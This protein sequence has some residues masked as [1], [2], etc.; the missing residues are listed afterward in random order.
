M[1]R[2]WPVEGEFH[3]DRSSLAKFT[4]DNEFTAMEFDQGIY[5]RQTKPAP[6]SVLIG[7]NF[8]AHDCIG[9]CFLFFLWNAGADVPK[10]CNQGVD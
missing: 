10:L 7:G 6:S 2:L 9:M 5:D 3:C 1:Q 4:I 8:P